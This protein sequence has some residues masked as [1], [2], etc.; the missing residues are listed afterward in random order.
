MNTLYNSLPISILRGWLFL[1]VCFWSIPMSS[2]TLDKEVSFD[3]GSTYV[4]SGT[5]DVNTIFQ[6]RIQYTF[7]STTSS[8]SNVEITDQL[9]PELQFVTLANSP[10]ATGSYD[11]GTHTVTFN[12]SD[13][14]ASG[15][16]GEVLI[17]VRFPLGTYTNTVATNGAT[18]TGTGISPTIVSTTVTASATNGTNP[19]TIT[20]GG[21]IVKW[22]SADEVSIG[23]G[24]YWQV[25][26]GTLGGEVLNNYVIEDCFPQEFIF[27]QF[28]FDDEFV[29]S[30]NVTVKYKTWDNASC[31]PNS[32]WQT[33]GT[34]STSDE[35]IKYASSLG[36]PANTN[37]ACLRFEFDPIPAGTNFHVDRDSRIRFMGDI[38][39]VN[40][41]GLENDACGNLITVP[42]GGFNITNCADMTAVGAT[43]SNNY[44][45]TACDVNTTIYPGRITVLDIEKTFI[46]ND[47]FSP[48]EIVRVEFVIQS[49]P[50]NATDLTNPVIVDLLPPELEYVGNVNVYTNSSS[51]VTFTT[52]VFSSIANYNGTG[53]TL[54]QWEWNGANPATLAANTSWGELYIEFDLRVTTGTPDGTYSN[55]NN[56]WVDQ[57]VDFCQ[58]NSFVDVHDFDSDGN[59]TES[60]CGEEATFEVFLGSTGAGLDAQKWVKG[61]CDTIWSRFPRLWLDRARW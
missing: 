30:I 49:P 11:S 40:S 4:T 21:D 59:T 58:N 38:S 29:G 43:T 41:N 6:Y 14:I 57:T 44:S 45:D 18:M 46:T 55:I 32:S 48:G 26:Y 5:V 54:I 25:R 15:A 22:N 24:I 42:P 31:T 61:E 28:R 19:P 36:L 50:E 1:F 3:D 47:P 52:P 2:Q 8:F 37:I 34:Y 35:S 9:P 12:F 17:Y 51:S 33:W 7:P 20:N 10:H 13:P 56:G 39:T 53:R 27:E 23:S 16:T 60:F